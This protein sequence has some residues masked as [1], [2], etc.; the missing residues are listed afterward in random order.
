[1]YL[2]FCIACC[3]LVVHWGVE[4]SCF[5]QV[6][7]LTSLILP[8]DRMEAALTNISIGWSLNI[9]FTL[10][11]MLYI[12]LF[13]TKTAKSE[14]NLFV[15]PISNVQF[16]FFHSVQ[17]VKCGAVQCSVV[18][19]IES[20]T[21]LSC[22]VALT[23]I[24]LIISFLQEHCLGITMANLITKIKVYKHHLWEEDYIA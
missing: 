7:A 8:T 21:L 5:A 6:G 15:F 17:A 13:W 14:H 24:L 9:Y 23:Q 20:Q 4:F 18:H 3:G 10:S 12:V 22:L 16:M 19:C 2:V 11:W 1:M